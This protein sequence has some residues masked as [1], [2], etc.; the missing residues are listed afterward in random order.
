[1]NWNTLVK[2]ARYHL[3]GGWIVFIAAPWV[4]L[5]INFA[6]YAAGAG[7]AKPPPPGQF[8]GSGAVFAI[9]ICFAIPGVMGIIRSLPFA[10]SLGVSRRA[11][12]AGTALLGTGLAAVYGLALAV[13][14]VIERATTGWGVHLS[15]FQ[16]SYILAGPWYLTWLTSFAGLAVVFVYGMWFGLIY[17]RWDVAGLLVFAAAQVIAGGAGALAAT[18][19]GA[20]PAIGRFFTT[21][22]AAGLTGVIAALAVVLLAGGYTT[23]RRVTV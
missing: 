4:V 12:Y 22:G 2:V 16:V 15:F 13:L 10:L 1:M 17:W 23:M 8:Y 5:A 9:Y 14:A 6:L 7:V 3:L 11:Y 18:R 20:W 19:T 21:L